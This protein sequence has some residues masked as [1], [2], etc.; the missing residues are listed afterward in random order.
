MTIQRTPS[1]EMMKEGGKESPGTMPPFVRVRVRK[2]R[3]KDKC[4]PATGDN[5][6]PPVCL[7]YA[8][9]ADTECESVLE[10]KVRMFNCTK[11][12]TT[13]VLKIEIDKK[14]SEQDAFKQRIGGNT[15]WKFP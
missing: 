11:K 3:T 10:M 2:S 13:R 1:A 15:T 12:S 5:L 8:I 4:S 9:V 6:D 14:Y 7:F